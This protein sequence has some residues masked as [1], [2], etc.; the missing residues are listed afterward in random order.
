MK[1][2]TVVVPVVVIDALACLIQLLRRLS[3]DVSLA[4][5]SKLHRARDCGLVAV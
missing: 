2:V 4:R 1:V 3:A 5:L